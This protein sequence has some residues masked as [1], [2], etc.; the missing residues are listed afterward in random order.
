MDRRHFLQLGGAASLIGT[1]PQALMALGS[2]QRVNTTTLY[3][4]T[5]HTVS[6]RHRIWSISKHG[7]IR[8]NPL[9]RRRQ[10][11]LFPGPFL[12]GVACVLEGTLF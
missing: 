12:L 6:W 5:R 4:P 9:P 1:V 2:R 3:F 11:M 10:V 8:L 7:S